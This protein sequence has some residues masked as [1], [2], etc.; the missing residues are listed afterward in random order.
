MFII[1]GVLHSWWG[2]ATKTEK[3]FLIALNLA[4]K[5]MWKI[6]TVFFFFITT[7][8]YYRLT[9]YCVLTNSH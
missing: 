2:T 6:W 4:Q 1:D 9:A 7:L 3:E 5:A 8:T